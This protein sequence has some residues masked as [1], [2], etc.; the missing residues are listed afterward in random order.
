M[1]VT[2]LGMASFICLQCMYSKGIEAISLFAWSTVPELHKL[3]LMYNVWGWMSQVT[4]SL[5]ASLE[6]LLFL[7]LHES[8]FLLIQQTEVQEGDGS[9]DTTQKSP[10]EDISAIVCCSCRYNSTVYYICF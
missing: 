2:W 8:W 1:H 3:K 10:M 4:G 9:G 6:V 7:D 5:C